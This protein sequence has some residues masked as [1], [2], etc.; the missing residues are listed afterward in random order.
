M[1]REQRKHG[2]VFGEIRFDDDAIKV[3]D[4]RCDRNLHIA[5]VKKARSRGAGQPK[6]TNI[7]DIRLQHPAGN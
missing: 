1:L 7:R 6:E 5:S 2:P 3:E 4:N